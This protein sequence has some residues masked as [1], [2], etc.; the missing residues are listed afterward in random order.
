L[1]GGLLFFGIVLIA[2]I[3]LIWRVWRD[4]F[5]GE[6]LIVWM[7]T[8]LWIYY[9]TVDQFSHSY[10]TVVH[11]FLLAGV[12]ASLLASGRFGSVDGRV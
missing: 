3:G 1:I 12:I 2:S 6:N 10:F 4:G 7:L 8:A 11:F 5:D 9:F